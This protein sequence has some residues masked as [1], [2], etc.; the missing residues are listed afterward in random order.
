MPIQYEVD[1]AAM[2]MTTR[3]TGRITPAMLFEYL[4]AIIA[5]PTNDQCDELMIFDDVDIDAISS[6]DVRALAHRSAE[7]SQD[8]KFR[9][10]VVAARDADF[11]MVRMFQAFRELDEQR[12]AVFRTLEAACQW[13][14]VDLP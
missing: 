9:V 11:G 12:M 13:L 2:L 4:D 3:A 5:D 14:G 1:R 7:L 8:D 6:A 10:A